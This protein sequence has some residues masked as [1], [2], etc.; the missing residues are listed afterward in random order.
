MKVFKILFLIIAVITSNLVFA[1]QSN[2]SLIEISNR[3]NNKFYQI[4]DNCLIVAKA[5]KIQLKK[6]GIDSEI[7]VI[8]PYFSNTKH[9]VLCVDDQCV[10]N[11][12][13]STSTFSKRALSDYGTI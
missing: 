1:T 8:N 10:D 11:G 7:I 12:D 3:I 4:P 5:K 6:I 9:A 13:I 2:L